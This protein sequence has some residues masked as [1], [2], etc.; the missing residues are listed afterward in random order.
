[1]NNGGGGKILKT[2]KDLP[3][4]RFKKFRRSPHLYGRV[5]KVG[6]YPSLLETSCKYMYI[7]WN[8]K[9]LLI[10]KKLSK[11]LHISICGYKYRW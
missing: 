7:V 10:C 8:S 2:W 4:G 5:G 3:C 11:V 9:T 6:D 1:M